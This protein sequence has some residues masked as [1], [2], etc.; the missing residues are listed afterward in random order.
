MRQYLDMLE[1]VL[2]DGKSKSDRTGTG[3]VAVF[4]HQFRHDL[5]SGFPLLTTKK[6]PFRLI[7]HELLWFIAGDTN[8]KYLH[9]HGVT[10]WD[11]WASET[12]DLG[13][14]YGK[15]WRSWAGSI[16]QLANAVQ[17]IK[18]NPDSRRIIVTA[19][20][21]SELDQMALPPCH[22]LFQFQVHD[23]RLSC[24]MYQR[25]ADTFL[26][27]PFNIASYALLTHM[28]AQATGLQVG[29]LVISFGDLHL[30]NNHLDQARLQ[31]SRDPHPLPQLILNPTVTDLFAFKFEDIGLFNYVAHHP[32]SAAVSK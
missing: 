28:M 22:L 10:I 2:T 9:D 1:R 17:T 13:P 11:E 3:T 29:D 24:S 26:G 4:G 32:I 14:V 27:V 25:S 6:I 7:V 16:D 19:W 31:L 20:N 30:Y 21:P 5:A 8:I 15:Q 12:G 23:G 18:S